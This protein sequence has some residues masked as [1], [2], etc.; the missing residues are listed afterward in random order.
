MTTI[1]KKR[2]DKLRSCLRW[3]LE[4]AQQMRGSYLPE[5]QEQEMAEFDKRVRKCKDALKNR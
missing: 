1:E 4:W 5:Y 2:M 3:A